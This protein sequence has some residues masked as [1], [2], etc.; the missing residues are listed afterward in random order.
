MNLSGSPKVQCHN[1]LHTT[2][3]FEQQ[4]IFVNVPAVLEHV[5]SRWQ[6]PKRHDSGALVNET[7]Q[8]WNAT[9]ADT[10]IP[11]DLLSNSKRAVSAV[12]LTERSKSQN[13]E[14]LGSD[15]LHHSEYIP[16]AR[17]VPPCFPFSRINT[18]P[19]S[20][21][22]WQLPIQMRTPPPCP[23]DVISILKSF[24]F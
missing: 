14:D 12:E 7:R 21:K 4:F 23:E 5:E 20:F 13:Y 9:C 22:G 18:L 8:V 16:L 19:G 17:V 3:Y 24:F 11:S 6:T 1:L 2:Q 10:L 15:Y